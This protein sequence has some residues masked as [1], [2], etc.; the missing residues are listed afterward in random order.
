MTEARA[1]RLT[2]LAFAYVYPPDAGSGTYRT[3]YFANEWARAGDTVMIVSVQENDF[4]PETVSD[5]ELCSLI[6][7]S[8]TIKRASALRPYRWLLRLRAALRR[9]FRSAAVTRSVLERP[10]RAD[11]S[12]RGPLKQLAAL[13]SALLTFP[14]EHSGWIPGAVLQALKITRAASVDCLYATGGPWS[15]LVAATL[16]NVVT[17]IPLIL[18]FRDPWSGN[19]N[20]NAHPG[21]IRRAHHRLEAL[22]VRRASRVVANTPQLRDDLLTRYRNLDPRRFIC[23]TN[24]FQDTPREPPPPASKLTLVHAGALYGSRSPR[25]LLEALAALLNRGTIDPRLI[26]VHLVGGLDN[27]DPDIASLLERLE[28]IVTVTPRVSH[29][30]IMELQ[31]GAGALLL[32]QTGYP[33]QIPRKLFEYLPLSLPIVAI[34]DLGSATARVLE[35]LKAPYCAANVPTEITATLQ[36]L[37]DDWRMGI[38]RPIDASRCMIYQNRTLAARLREELLA[39]IPA[40]S[41]DGVRK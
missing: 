9:N 35:D 21:Y 11:V 19:P 12:A 40:L 6:E 5:P 4:L 10:E 2:V 15:T 20:L 31:R 33:L 16:T 3:L 26:D 32:I 41:S 14:D 24:G 18:D 13:A 7:P 36:R 34:V 39:S 28:D 38:A 30:K 8:I 23:V 27:D 1:K 37:Y 25:Y 29:N 22:C 17:G